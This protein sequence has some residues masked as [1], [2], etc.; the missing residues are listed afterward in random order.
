[1]MRMPTLPPRWLGTAAAKSRQ[2]AEQRLAKAKLPKTCIVMKFLRVLNQRFGA[3]M[4]ENVKRGGRQINVPS[5]IWG[6]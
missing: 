5:V 1:M 4:Q 6:Q 3:C 2:P